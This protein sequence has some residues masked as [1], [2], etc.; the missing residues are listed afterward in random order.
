[1]QKFIT[2][3]KAIGGF[4]RTPSAASARRP[5]RGAAGES[6]ASPAIRLCCPRLFDFAAYIYTVLVAIYT[7]HAEQ[8]FFFFGQTLGLG[9]SKTRRLRHSAICCP[10]IREKSGLRFLLLPAAVAFRSTAISQRTSARLWRLSEGLEIEVRPKRFLNGAHVP[11]RPEFNKRF[12]SI[13]RFCD[14]ANGAELPDADGA[15]R[16]DAANFGR[17]VLSCIEAEFCKQICD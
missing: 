7:S 2:Y 1:M 11:E 8:L 13:L 12:F 10:R 15:P 16:V 4:K 14:F 3:R 17:P 5:R 6:G 9:S